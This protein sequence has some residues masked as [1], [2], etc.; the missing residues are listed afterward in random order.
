MMSNNWA[1]F[2]SNCAAIFKFCAVPLPK[3]SFK[4]ILKANPS[5]THPIAN[6]R[7]EMVSNSCANFVLNCA[8]IF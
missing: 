8:A 6:F 3:I 2:V 7:S 4:D 5:P 1:N